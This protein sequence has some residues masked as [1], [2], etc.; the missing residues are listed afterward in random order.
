MITKNLR[1]QEVV[2]AEALVDCKVSVMVDLEVLVMVDWEVLVMVDWEAIVLVI[3]VGGKG[4]DDK[5][6]VVKLATAAV[7]HFERPGH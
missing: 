1:Y 4:L 6:S 3:W 2:A 5:S 7:P